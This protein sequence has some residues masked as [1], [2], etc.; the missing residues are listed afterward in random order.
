MN[1]LSS[2]I[3]SAAIAAGAANATTLGVACVDTVLVEVFDFINECRTETTCTA[4]TDFTDNLAALTTTWDMRNNELGGTAV[5]VDYT[6]STEV[7]LALQD[8]AMGTLATYV[9]DTA[10]L[11]A[12]TW[13][14][15]LTLGSELYTTEWLSNTTFTSMTTPNGTT[16]TS[17]AAT[18]GAVTGSLTES[19]YFY[20]TY[21]IDP[22]DMMRFII[23]NDGSAKMFDALFDSAEEG[24]YL[25]LGA[26]YALASGCTMDSTTSP[27]VSCSMVFDIV[28]ATGYTN[29]SDVAACDAT[30]SYGGGDCD[31]E[32]AAIAVFEAINDM[33]VYPATWALY[34]T[35]DDAA[36]LYTATNT[37]TIS[38]DFDDTD[39]N[40]NWNLVRGTTNL[41]AT[42]TALAAEPCDTALEW[43]GGL[44]M[45]AFD[46]ATYLASATA[47]SSV[48][49]GD[50]T[51]AER[52]AEY[53]TATADS[54][55]IILGSDYSATWVVL[56]ML[57]DDKDT[58]DAS[59]TAL[60]N[61]SMA[62]IGIMSTANDAF[63]TV[64]VA[65][66][67]STFTES[68]DFECE[69]TATVTET[70]D[71]AAGLAAAATAVIAAA[72]LM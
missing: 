30:I 31:P 9:T 27:E 47:L 32:D 3:L 67:D 5:T 33:R 20:T 59:R 70:V 24:N 66:L 23:S 38:A 60:L 43:T 36:A 44:A 50:S 14:E 40:S 1:H 16:T 12:M 52:V 57:I 11:T 28:V 46:Q 56:E 64:Y 62:Q 13:S 55:E 71:A 49:S 58:T 72:L 17:R 25:Y 39:V 15:G 54:T 10:A 37:L 22:L 26:S 6:G 53:G 8:T 45:A 7:T 18:N 48:G 29:N 2:Y 63:T 42:A 68:D 4:A 35:A 65:A 21:T 41:D 34:I 51:F 19:V 61:A 69:A